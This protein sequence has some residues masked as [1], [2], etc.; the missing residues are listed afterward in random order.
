LLANLHKGFWLHLAQQRQPDG[1]WLTQEIQGSGDAR[2]AL[3]VHAR[4]RFEEEL[5]KCHLFSV[6]TQQSTVNP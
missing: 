1:V 4:F 5:E 2:A 6:T 3:F